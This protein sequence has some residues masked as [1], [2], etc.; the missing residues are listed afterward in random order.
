MSIV[1]VV[2][3]LI[4]AGVLQGKVLV[5]N[6]H[7]RSALSDLQKYEAAFSTFKLKYQHLPGDINNAE[8]YWGTEASLGGIGTL[9]GSGNG[10]VHLSF[11][12]LP[13]REGLRVWEHL[14]LAGLLTDQ[15]PGCGVT[16]TGV[17]NN[18]GDLVPGVNIPEISIKGIGIGISDGNNNNI[19]FNI[20]RKSTVGWV[21][22]YPAFST[23]DTK[24]M[25]LKID[26]GFPTMGRFI[27]QNGQLG[28]GPITICRQSGGPSGGQYVLSAGDEE[29][30]YILY[31]PLIF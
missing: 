7:L 16:D 18:T 13:T 5:K 11:Y 22:R 3:A 19:Y 6:M 30:C 12:G 24:A 21:N 14:G 27:G 15:Y 28:G 25:D 1:I 4:I 26:D 17:Y 10:I 8:S 23:I 31:S 20:G 9:N 29:R 2:I